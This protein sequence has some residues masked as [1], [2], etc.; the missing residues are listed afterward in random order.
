MA[1]ARSVAAAAGSVQAAMRLLG[2]KKLPK[3]RGELKKHFVAAAKN[4]HPDSKLPGKR[5]PASPPKHAVGAEHVKQATLAPR[6]G[7][8]DMGSLTDA[9]AT[10]KGLY[11]KETGEISADARMIAAGFG[12]TQVGGKNAV[13]RHGFGIELDETAVPHSAKPEDVA[14]V[15]LPWLKGKPG[16]M[17]RSEAE[18]AGTL[19]RSAAAARGALE[20]GA[21]AAQKK[22]ANAK[23][24]LRFVI[25][26]Y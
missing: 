5:A 12:S 11:D 17:R 22:A 18:N 13:D 1:G 16:S 23:A 14:E 26:G 21:Q 2:I 3:T 20:K 6:G 10:L 4:A 19:E 25:A 7:T 24:A 8:E 15:M 9:F